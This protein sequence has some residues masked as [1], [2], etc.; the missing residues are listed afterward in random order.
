MI[1]R[2][3]ALIRAHRGLM[4]KSVAVRG[5]LTLIAL[6]PPYV[7]KILIDNVY[8]SKSVSLLEFV[9]VFNAGV[10]VMTG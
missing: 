10:A 4:I 6:I 5:L 9:L 8:P 1:D 7:T 3:M 2:G